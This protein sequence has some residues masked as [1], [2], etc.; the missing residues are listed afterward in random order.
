MTRGRTGDC[1]GGIRSLGSHNRRV[2]G[3][4]GT[5]FLYYPVRGLD[6]STAFLVKIGDWWRRCRSRSDVRIERARASFAIGDPG[7]WSSDTT[8]DHAM[9]PVVIK[10]TAERSRDEIKR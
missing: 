8:S 2:S 4:E 1:G 3:E 9:T 6:G 10:S 7:S 5:Y